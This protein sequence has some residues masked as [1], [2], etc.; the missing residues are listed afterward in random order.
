MMICFLFV[1]YGIVKK[2]GIPCHDR[3]NGRVVESHSLVNRPLLYSVDCSFSLC[4]ARGRV[5][6]WPLPPQMFITS[7][8]MTAVGC[9]ETISRT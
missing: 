3:Q 7:F 4:E 1:F 5:E 6:E 9:S 2:M 8:S